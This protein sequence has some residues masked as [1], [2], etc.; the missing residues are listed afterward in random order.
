[1]GD[2]N[3]LHEKWS[4]NFSTPFKIAICF[5]AQTIDKFDF[6]NISALFPF[7]KTEGHADTNNGKYRHN[8]KRN[9]NILCRKS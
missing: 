6:I 3:F 5:A 2:L 4:T 9:K 1:M 7:E 8:N